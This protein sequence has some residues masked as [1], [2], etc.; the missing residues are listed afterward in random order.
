MRAINRKELRQ[1]MRIGKFLR[2]N[3]RRVRK[4]RNAP[5][6][7]FFLST[8]AGLILLLGFSTGCAPSSSTGR[9]GESSSGTSEIPEL[10]DGMIQERINYTGIREVPEENGA[11][12]PISWSF[13][14]SEPKEI[15]VVEKKIEGDRATLV[16]E[17]KTR[18]APKSSKPRELQGRI[19]T[20]WRLQTGWVLRRWEIVDAENISMKFKNLPKPP[21]QNS[22]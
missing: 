12:D 14:E 3:M 6:R 9:G 5:R 18:S 19:R 15:S 20:E 21:E 1:K 4:P 10:T 8:L 13:D 22:K 17:I 7:A 16:L 11:A 2:L